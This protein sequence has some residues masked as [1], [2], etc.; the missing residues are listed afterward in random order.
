[1]PLLLHAHLAALKEFRKTQT[2]MEWGGPPAGADA[3][4]AI[5]RML[6]PQPGNAPPHTVRDRSLHNV[7]QPTHP[8]V[9]DTQDNSGHLARAPAG[10]GAPHAPVTQRHAAHLALWVYELRSLRGS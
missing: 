1:M 3:G 9:G 4:A 10:R 7:W 6:N 5:L 2:C 8:G